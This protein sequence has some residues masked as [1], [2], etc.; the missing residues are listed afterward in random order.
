MKRRQA[1]LRILG[2]GIAFIAAVPVE[3]MAQAGKKIP[4]IGLLV[5]GP[6]PAE[7]ACVA[8]LRAGLTEFGYI[9]G[10]THVLDIAWMEGQPVDVTRRLAAELVRRGVDVIVS[11]GSAGLVEAKPAM[12]G[13]PVVMAVSSYP[14]ERGLISSLSRPGG[15]IT[16]MATFFG[17][18]Y[19]KRMQL[20]AEALPGLSR[21]T[22]V[23]VPGDMSDVILRDLEAA[24]QRYALKL[25]VTEVNAA[26]DFAAVFQSAARDGAQAIMT[27]QSP[28]F[29]Q[30][31]RLIADLALKHRLPAFSGEPL[32]AEAGTLIAHGASIPHSCQRAAS[33][34]DR[35]LK[36]AK[37]SDLPAEQSTKYE[38]V[39]NL[40]TARALGV[41]L[42]QAILLRADKVI[43]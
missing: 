17:E 15:N 42:P 39:I 34:V 4:R 19:A 16:G 13:V 35:I 12:A 25:R 6:P 43:E 2:V 41:T 9:D 23:R 20:L 14:V 1:L 11:V 27:T 7:H 32:A 26:E 8:G 37:P 31:R 22:I 30:H 10:R 38:L 24:A 3:G 33:F 5:T 18:L 28:F 21:V 40:G 36:G 29:Y